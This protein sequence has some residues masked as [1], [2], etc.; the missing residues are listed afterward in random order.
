[1]EGGKREG[2]EGILNRPKNSLLKPTTP[3]PPKKTI[4]KA[5]RA[6]CEKKVRKVKTIGVKKYK[7]KRP[8]IR[9]SPVGPVLRPY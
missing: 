3:S 2:L 6:F 7:K 9:D 5:R 4:E 1:V 8:K